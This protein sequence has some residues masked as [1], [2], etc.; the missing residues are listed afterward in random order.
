MR[1]AFSVKNEYLV[2]AAIPDE[3]SQEKAYEKKKCF[4]PRARSF[5][6]PNIFQTSASDQIIAER[7]IVLD[8]LLYQLPRASECS[9]S[10]LVKI[11]RQMIVEEIPWVP[12][13]RLV[14]LTTSVVEH[15]R[16]KNPSLMNPLSPTKLNELRTESH[17]LLLEQQ[18]QF[19]KHSKSSIISNSL[20]HSYLAGVTPKAKLVVVI[21]KPIFRSDGSAA[22]FGSVFGSNYAESQWMLA[23]GNSLSH[24][25]VSLNS[26]CEI[27]DARTYVLA[28][29]E[30]GTTVM[31]DLKQGVLEPTTQYTA[32]LF[33][34]DSEGR[35]AIDRVIF[36][37]P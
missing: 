34:Y 8:R 31:L 2:H 17:S 30:K 37:V 33:C 7:S 6:T 18:L 24:T 28:I 20:S 3:K 10:D 15:F 1:K 12:I 27:G 11:A 21:S 19:Q 25:I 16:K 13:D 36:C 35:E 23:K 14:A 29:H 9:T 4:S 5:V 22:L 26:M 32:S